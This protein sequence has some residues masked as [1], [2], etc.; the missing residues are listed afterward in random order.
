M[1]FFVLLGLAVLSFTACNGDGNKSADHT[2]TMDV[3]D[4]VLFKQTVNTDTVFIQF[5]DGF[6]LHLVGMQ[7]SMNPDQPIE[8]MHFKSA[9]DTFVYELEMGQNLD[10]AQL[11]FTSKAL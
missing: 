8:S 1:K 3:A 9:S 10:V 4:S 2:D 6:E 11:C 7:R 5:E